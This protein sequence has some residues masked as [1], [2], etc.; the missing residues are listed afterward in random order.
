MEG[1]ARATDTSERF[2]DILTRLRS[3]VERLEGGNLSLEESLSSFEQ[4]MELCRRGAAILDAA[5]KKVEVLLSGPAG[6]TRTALP[7]VFAAGDVQDRIYR[8]AVTAAGTG[9]MA[10]LEAEK[11]LA[12]MPAESPAEIEELFDPIAYE[13]GAAVLRM[14]EAYVGADAFRQGVNQYLETH[15][16]GNATSED[17]SKALAATSGKP[18]ER[19]L[20]RVGVE[21]TDAVDDDRV[22]AS[23]GARVLIMRKV[24]ARHE[25]RSP[26]AKRWN[27]RVAKC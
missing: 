1:A 8:Q 26:A 20:Q 16:Y 25:Q 27:Q 2:D 12:H 23:G 24:R 9:C 3:I 22:E 4:G 15:A 7:G 18:V 5:E 19:I 21:S 10:A 17:F 14:I 6:S 13:K 11:W